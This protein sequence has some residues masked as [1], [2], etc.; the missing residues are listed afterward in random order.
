MKTPLLLLLAALPGSAIAA[1]RSSAN[2]SITADTIDAAGARAISANYSNAGSASLIAGVSSG[3]APAQ[4]AKHGYIAQLYDVS[5]LLLNSAAP[6]VNETVTLQLAAWQLLDDAT[7]LATDANAVTWS[8]A[9]GPLT[10]ISASGLATA[11]LVFENTPATVEG[12]FGGF[13][14]ALNFTVLDTI[15]DNFGAYAGDGISDDWQVQFFGQNN[16][17]AAPALDP[18][19]DGANNIFEFAAGLTPND[20]ASTFHMTIAPVPGQ[21]ARKRIIFSPR[22]DGRTYVVKFKSDLPGATWVPLTSSSFTDNGEERTVTD[23]SAIGPR[24]FYQLEITKP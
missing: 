11:G 9:S 14:G 5:G 4:I 24:R 6:D 10:S 1:P 8:I 21:P 19:G 22:L 13:T 20:P 12:A 15:P 7:F 18:D 2:Y 23:L 16:P 3:A 17:L